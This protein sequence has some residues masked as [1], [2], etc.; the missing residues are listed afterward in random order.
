MTESGAELEAACAI[1]LA[2]FL[3][4]NPNIARVWTL[5]DSA[6]FKVGFAAG[7]TYGIRT[8]KEALSK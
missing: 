2:K 5:A 7:A 3:A 6:A 1:A 4:E 8:L